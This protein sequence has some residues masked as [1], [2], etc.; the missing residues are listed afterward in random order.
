MR[1]PA[2]YLSRQPVI[3]RIPHR[4]KLHDIAREA[5][6]TKNGV[7]VDCLD[8]RQRQRQ[9]VERG[10]RWT[11]QVSWQS[12]VL[13]RFRKSVQPVLNKEMDATGSD[14]AH[15]DGI[16]V[17]NLLLNTECP[18]DGIRQNLIR[19]KTRACRSRIG[20]AEICASG[21]ATWLHATVR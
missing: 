15:F 7:V 14:I 5:E 1:K 12:P 21:N 13:S 4:R 3:E 8:L 18:L 6:R 10:L 20:L 16:V 11:L 2:R 17:M 9:R 19:N